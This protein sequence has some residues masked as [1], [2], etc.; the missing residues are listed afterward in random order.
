M[1]KQEIHAVIV[2]IA[3]ALDEQHTVL[4]VDVAKDAEGFNVPDGSDLS[5]ALRALGEAA[6]RLSRLAFKIATQGE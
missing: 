4:S 6:T 3:D 1:T 2:S 5:D